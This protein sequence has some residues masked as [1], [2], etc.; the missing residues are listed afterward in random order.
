MAAGKEL[1]W[2]LEV[3]FFLQFFKLSDL[4]MFN[5]YKIYI[6]H[7]CLYNIEYSKIHPFFCVQFGDI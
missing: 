5:I 2:D 3:W 1:A 4:L 6:L 7:I